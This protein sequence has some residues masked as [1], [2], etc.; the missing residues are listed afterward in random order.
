M[1]CY[2]QGNH[3]GDFRDGCADYDV[4]VVVRPSDIALS[5][6]SDN[7]ERNL[8]NSGSN[9]KTNNTD[10]DNMVCEETVIGNNM[11]KLDYEGNPDQDHGRKP[12]E[13]NEARNGG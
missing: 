11:K 9:S 8:H 13:N 4:L 6:T 7:P 10:K 12:D 2:C 1:Y 5:S 3:G